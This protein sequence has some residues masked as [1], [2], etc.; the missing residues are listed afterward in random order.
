MF[1][2][3]NPSSGVPIYLQVMGQVKHAIETGALR[4]GD[5]LPAIRSLAETLVINPNT[6]A[7]VYRELEH[8]G[9]LELRHGM[10]A[11]VTDKGHS[12]S[13]TNRVQAARPLVKQ[14]VEKLRKQGLSEEEIRRLVEAELAREAAVVRY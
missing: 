12:R 14:F 8:E 6:V 11:F 3:P 10:G 4:P 9:V 7:K 5:Q 2:K 1:N 13:R